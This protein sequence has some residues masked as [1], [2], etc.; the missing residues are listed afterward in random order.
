MHP[1]GRDK[2]GME[3]HLIRR[4][5]NKHPNKALQDQGEYHEVTVNEY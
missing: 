3:M 2:Y 1:F 4:S 5:L